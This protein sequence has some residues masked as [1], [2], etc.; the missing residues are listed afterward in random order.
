MPGMAVSNTV[1]R[2]DKS[3]ESQN[4]PI[5][6]SAFLGEGKTYEYFTQQQFGGLP[7]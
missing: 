6:V 7:L 1:T 4:S 2:G 5:F 3:L